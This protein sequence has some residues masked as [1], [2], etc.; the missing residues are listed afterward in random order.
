[1]KRQLGR[2]LIVVALVFC[3]ACVSSLPSASSFSVRRAIVPDADSVYQVASAI[4]K[5]HGY[6]L[7]H[8]H[9]QAD[10]ITTHPI[11]YRLEKSS[12]RFGTAK[13]GRRLAEIRM[14]HDD[15]ETTLFCRVILQRQTTEAHRFFALD[16]GG[17]DRPQR[18]P[19]ER[20]AATAHSQNT[21]WQTVGRDLPQERA[22]LADVLARVAAP[23]AAGP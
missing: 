2:A 19:I 22:I 9:K 13:V 3:G 18:T 12:R 20:E 10:R 7:D 6:R 4:L 14:H 8:A 5:D 15:D 11:E 23:A 1:M 16:G 21:V 17:D